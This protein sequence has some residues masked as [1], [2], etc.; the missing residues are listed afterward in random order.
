[1]QSFDNVAHMLRSMAP[2]NPVYCVFPRVYAA[3]TRRFLDGF[4]GRVLYAVKA[5]N[6]PYV[7]R[8]LL[9]AGVSHFDCASLAEVAQVR[10]LSRD[11]RIYY[12][13]PV[14]IPGAAAT[15]QSEHGVRHFVIDHD[16][17][18]APLL[19]EVD[20]ARSVVFARMAVSHAT[21]RVDLS[22][23]FG[24][25]P[26]AVGTLLEAIAAA[27]AEP[28][29]AFNV[30]SFVMSPDAFAHAFDT[31]HAVLD[32]LPFRVRLVDIGGGFPKSYP[33]LSA[34]PLEQFFDAIRGFD[35][36][37]LATGG[38]LLA[39]PGRA[40]VARGMSAV[41]R[42]LLRKDDRLYLNDGM[43]GAFW[44]LRFRVHER[45]A[46]KAYRGA[47]PLGGPP[48]PFRLYG[49]TCDSDDK[50]PGLVELPDT[51]AAGDYV[52]FGSVGAY[53]LSGR[54]DFNGFYSD[55]IVSI[56]SPDALP[57]Q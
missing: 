38:E 56:D 47:D 37:P 29:L 57:P 33:G 15:A 55:T 25:P 44:E 19:A 30:G 7:L 1:M 9:D 21:S 52:E 45:Y 40:L 35:A 50:L 26:D 48:R 49:P 39:E 14:R 34:P 13:N 6:D 5:N 20:A 43:Y 4:P 42:V 54:T 3:T 51:I 41:V 16:S 46:A 2:D 22:S 32:R 27:G 53:S 18:L 36:L 8:C 28:A 12:M 10:A 23:K 24:A 31:A 11:A 17:G